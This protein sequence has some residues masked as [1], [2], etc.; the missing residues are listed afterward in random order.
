M[1]VMSRKSISQPIYITVEPTTKQD[2]LLLARFGNY[3]AILSFLVLAKIGIQV[4]NELYWLFGSGAAGIEI[5][6]LINLINR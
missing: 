2:R 5:G 3:L 1:L 4:P 6:Q